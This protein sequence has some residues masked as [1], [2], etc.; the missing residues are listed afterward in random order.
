VEKYV[1]T[2]SSFTLDSSNCW[3]SRSDYEV[4]AVTAT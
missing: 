1:G 2:S 3:V 4:T